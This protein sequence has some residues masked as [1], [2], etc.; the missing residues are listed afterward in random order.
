M[1]LS[2]GRLDPNREGV[3]AKLALMRQ[4]AASNAAALAPPA[5]ALASAASR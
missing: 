1:P 3:P 2:P 5:P 4:L